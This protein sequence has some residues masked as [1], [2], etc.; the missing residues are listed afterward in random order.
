MFVKGDNLYIASAGN[1]QI[2]KMDLKTEQVWR[3]AGTGR[4]A[5]ADGT[6]LEAA[7]NQPSGLA[8]HNNTLY[9]AD[10]EA[11]AIRA[12]NLDNGVV[13]TLIGTGLFDFGDVDG[14]LDG[15]QLQ[16]AMGIAIYQNQLY[17]AD[18]YNGKIKEVNLD[19]N[20][21]ATVLA[22]LDE[23]NDVKFID[24]KM[25]VTDTNHHQLIKVDLITGEKF[26]V[27]IV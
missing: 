13:D 6:L 2:L 5:L 14:D 21:I 22:G 10:A 7:F 3:F 25:W 11:S 12:I 15:A 19:N 8:M 26:L 20:R 23:P 1:H 24:G 4:E 16:H 9:V 18:T 27:S 17:I